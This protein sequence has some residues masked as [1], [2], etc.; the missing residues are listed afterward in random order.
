MKYYGEDLRRDDRGQGVQGL[1]RHRLIRGGTPIVI[2]IVIV[3]VIIIVT[4]IVLVI[5]A[6]IVIVIVM[7]AIASFATGRRSGGFTIISKYSI[8]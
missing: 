2:V 4:V 5:V 6:V 1:G 3:I 8:V 7:A